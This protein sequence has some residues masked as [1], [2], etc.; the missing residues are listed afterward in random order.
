MRGRGETARHVNG[1]NRAPT[2]SSSARDSATRGD[3]RE[4]QSSIDDLV[5]ALV[6][7]DSLITVFGDFA[8]APH[9]ISCACAAMDDMSRCN[10]VHITY[11]CNGILICPLVV[12]HELEP[13]SVV[14]C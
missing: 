8:L 12:A 3:A 5:S 10:L 11:L 13:F 2:T 14:V 4:Q 6:T 9:R 7:Q 1:T